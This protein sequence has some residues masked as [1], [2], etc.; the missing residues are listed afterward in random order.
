[1]EMVALSPMLIP[2]LDVVRVYMGRVRRGQN[3][4]LP[5]KTHIHHKLLAIGMNQRVAMVTIV[6]T[7]IILSCLFIYLS[8][9]VNITWIVIGG[10]VFYTVANIYLSKLISDG[11]KVFNCSV[12]VSK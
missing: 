11:K 6:A 12:Q 10:G 4:F 1:M 7:S 9:F 2:C 8:A 3:P 5:D